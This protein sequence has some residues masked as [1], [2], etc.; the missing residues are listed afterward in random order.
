MCV[1]SRLLVLVSPPFLLCLRAAPLHKP[2][3]YGSGDNNPCILAPVLLVLAISFSGRGLDLIFVFPIGTLARTPRLR[4]HFGCP[5]E[6][7]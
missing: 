4:L 2:C 3:Y 7:L 6:A 5:R 1:I